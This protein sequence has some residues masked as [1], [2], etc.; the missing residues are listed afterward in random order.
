MKNAWKF[1]VISLVFVILAVT[2][3]PAMAGSWFRSEKPFTP[4]TESCAD[5]KVELEEFLISGASI[6]SAL[7]VKVMACV[8]KYENPAADKKFVEKSLAAAQKEYR[9]LRQINGGR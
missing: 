6:P 7:K 4:S 2:V 9:M 8:V 3:S 1:V 5:V